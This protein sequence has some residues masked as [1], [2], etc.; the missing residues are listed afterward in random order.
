MTATQ[1]HAERQK[2][3]AA[4]LKLI[5]KELRKHATKQ[6]RDPRNWGFA[7]SLGYVQ[8]ELT[9]VLAFLMGSELEDVDPLLREARKA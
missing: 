7:G 1:K 3:I 6:K 8:D 9:E 5:Q 4:L 2:D